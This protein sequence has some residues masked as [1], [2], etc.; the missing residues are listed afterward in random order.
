MARETVRLRTAALGDDAALVGAAELGP[1]R[2][3]DDPLA[4][5]TEPVSST[6]G[7]RPAE[8]SRGCRETRARAVG[9]GIAVD[10]V[11]PG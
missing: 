7:V 5:F 1:A 3:V 6:V 2:L 8:V 9:T 11:A 10:A 4:V